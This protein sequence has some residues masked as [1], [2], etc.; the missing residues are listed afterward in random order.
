M[1]RHNAIVFGCGALVGLA[2]SFNSELMI[3]DLGFS[4]G[5]K[6]FVGEWLFV[7]LACYV[8]SRGEQK[9]SLTA[10]GFN[11]RQP[12]YLFFS[13]GLFFLGSACAALLV[14]PFAGGASRVF[15]TFLYFSFALMVPAY[16]YVWLSAKDNGVG[17]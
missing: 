6:G 1:L 13:A 15:L 8:L 10:S 4:N 5:V 11:W 14:I 3:I 7:W 9:I 17:R 12:C 2:I 16:G